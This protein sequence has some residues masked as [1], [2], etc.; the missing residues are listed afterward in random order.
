MVKATAL[1]TQ[2][3]IGLHRDFWV[4]IGDLTSGRIQ[5]QAIVIH[6]FRNTK[7]QADDLRSQKV[8]ESTLKLLTRLVVLLGWMAGKG[9]FRVP[10][11]SGVACS[12]STIRGS[13][14]CRR[15]G[16][17]PGIPACRKDVGQESIFPGRAA[18]TS[19]F[20]KPREPPHSIRFFPATSSATRF[21][22]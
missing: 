3:W 18:W 4:L 13:A 7:N 22:G 14:D 17:E 6:R 15:A 16:A 2:P 10:E 1:E 12:S 8:A 21:L 9:G 20:L 5:L 19:L 11:R